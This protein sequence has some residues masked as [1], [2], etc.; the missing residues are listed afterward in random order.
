MHA[1]EGRAMP[2]DGDKI[3]QSLVGSPL[4]V[5]LKKMLLGE[6][7]HPYVFYA[8]PSSGKTAAARAFMHVSIP[9]EKLVLDPAKRPKAL[10]L[11]GTMA[12]ESGWYFEH[13]GI[14]FESGTTPWFG[15]L[16][17]AL[18]QTEQE[19]EAGRKPSVLILD[20]FEVLGP[21][22]I[23][24]TNMRK[25]CHDL[26]MLREYDENKY[27]MFI[28]VITQ[29]KEV[30]NE[31]CRINNWKKISLMPG[32]FVPPI[33]SC[34]ENAQT[35]LPDPDWTGLP[36]ERQQLENMVVKR[37]KPDELNG[38]DWRPLCGDGQNPGE[39]IKE[40]K[41]RVNSKGC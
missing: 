21:E 6:A 32:S 37:F 40:I 11:T 24:I 3:K 35:P 36:W 31:L 4:L 23:N 8:P 33:L 27:E 12:N 16:I 17:A 22:N 29:S 2:K 5:C 26:A 20:D 7:A 10:M 25:L 18:S 28:V 30:A 19:V 9:G 39:I 41:G 1:P 14:T 34:T 15:P 13:I 38:I